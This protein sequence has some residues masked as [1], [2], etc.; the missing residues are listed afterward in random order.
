MHHTI[1]P[2]I[3]YF[4]TPV[5]LVTTQN[6]DGTPNISPMSSAWWLGH[7]CVIGLD[8]SSQGTKNLI[9]RKYCVLNLPSDA[10][11]ESINRIARTTGSYPVPPWK[12]SVGYEYVKDKFRRANLTEQASDLVPVPRIKEC[13]VQ[14]EAEVMEAHEM[15]K[16]L[17][18]RKGLILSIE[19]KILRVH[20]EDELRLPGYANRVDADKW[21][22]MIMCFQD[23]YSKGH[24]KLAIS[25]LAKVSE[26]NY[27]AFTR[28]DVVKQG[29]D[30]DIVGTD[31]DD[32]QVRDSD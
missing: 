28:S 26:G 2:A 21:N 30:T 16:D 32:V 13:P 12:A 15:M 3:L 31:A 19:L 10:M 17:P 8:A 5:V 27:R 25:N 7:R 11:A 24:K 20:I 6:E 14:M 4:G 18:D 1:S 9:R 22:P 29:S 23:F